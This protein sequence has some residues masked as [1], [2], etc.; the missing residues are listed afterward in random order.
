[1]VF[2]QLIQF[3]SDDVFK[4]CVKRYNGDYNNKGLTCWKQ[5]LCMAF[6]QLTHRES[7]SDT[8]LCLRLHKDKLYHLGI[9]RAFDKSTIARANENRDW[10]VPADSKTSVGTGTGSFSGSLT[11]LTPSTPYFVRA[12]ATNSAGTGYGAAATFT[13]LAIQP[14]TVID[15]DG[16]VYHIVTIGT[17]EW[18]VDRLPGKKSAKMTQLYSTLAEIYHAMYRHIFD[19]DQEFAFYDSL[20]KAR[21]CHKILE[22]GCGSGML[23]RRFMADG[24]DYLGLDLYGEMLEIA[25]L[26]TGSDLFV[27]CDMRNLAFDREFDAVLITGRSI[28]YVTE[29]EGIMNTL[30]GVHKA[31]R[32]KGLFVFG[33]FE[34]NGIF[35]NF[36]DFEQTIPDG[37][38]VI[39]RISTL[40]KNLS[41]GWTYDWH[42][43]YAIEEKGEVTEYDD[44][45]TLRAFTRDEILLFLKL[46]GFTVQ[47][48]IEEEKALTL[49]VKSKQP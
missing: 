48:V 35:D 18:L 13:T 9:G 23:A 25:R 43:R 20:L 39:R 27:Q 14:G 17:Q 42:A 11:G 31:L 30:A 26:E 22:I 15:I 33:I 36:N 10:R 44:L 1:M 32:D 24:Y 40:K 6:G 12:F 7:L 38:R 19:Y 41:T 5:F 28:A 3:A 16:N 8:A 49:I 4:G 21:N 45:T 29:N 37:E 47:E 2:T 46:T 34:A